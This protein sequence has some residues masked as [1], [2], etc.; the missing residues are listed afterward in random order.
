LCSRTRKRKK[1]RKAKKGKMVA[2]LK[3][4]KIIRWAINDKKDWERKEKIEENHRKIKEM[5]PKKF[6]K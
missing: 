1:E 3:E 4:E 5:V 2:I 6:L